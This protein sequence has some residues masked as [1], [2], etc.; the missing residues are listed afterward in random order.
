MMLGENEL[1]RVREI[2]ERTAKGLL[3]RKTMTAGELVEC[4]AYSY[5]REILL[6]ML[7]AYRDSLD[8]SERKFIDFLIER[9]RMAYEYHKQDEFYRVRHNILVL[10]YMVS[11]PMAKRDIC[12]RLSIKSSV[13][14]RNLKKGIDELMVHAFGVEGIRWE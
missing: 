12:S 13:Y 14:D 11:E 10:R 3:E 1:A 2:A 7:E 8:N 5:R 4:A 9:H 6:N